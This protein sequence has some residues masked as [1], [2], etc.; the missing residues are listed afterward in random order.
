MPTEEQ[1]RPRATPALPL[2]ALP[3][4]L[5]PIDGS[6]DH[7]THQLLG[8][9][10]DCARPSRGTTSCRG[11]RATGISPDEQEATLVRISISS[12]A[13]V[14]RSAPTLPFRQSLGGEQPLQAETL[15]LRGHDFLR[16]NVLSRFMLKPHFEG[17]FTG[18]P[19]C[20]CQS[21]KTPVRLMIRYE[22][23]TTRRPAQALALISSC[24]AIPRLTASLPS[25][26]ELSLVGSILCSSLLV[27]PITPST[28]SRIETSSPVAVGQEVC[29][30]CKGSGRSLK[31]AID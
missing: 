21:R 8:A 17:V 22:D 6:V 28:R 10:V 1:V 31:A 24:R 16:D 14:G 13:T 15:S 7:S 25:I 9:V 4:R 3:R 23:S 5:Q 19:P 18:G 11:L 27:G 2:Q 12:K 30:D 29:G 26:L 20:S